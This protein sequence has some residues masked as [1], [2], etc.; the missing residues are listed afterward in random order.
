MRPKGGAVEPKAAVQGLAMEG[1][2]VCVRACLARSLQAC[3]CKRA[4][5]QLHSACVLFLNIP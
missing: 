1:E 5:L 2:C 4:C 3:M